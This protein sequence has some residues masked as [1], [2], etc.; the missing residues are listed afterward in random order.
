MLYFIFSFF[1]DEGSTI[2]ESQTFQ[3]FESF[4]NVN[5]GKP[6]AL[7]SS[8]PFLPENISFNDNKDKSVQEIEEGSGA[9]LPFQQL[10][11]QRTEQEND[12]QASEQPFQQ[13][14][15]NEEEFLKEE[16]IFESSGGSDG[17]S[18][19]SDHELEG[20]GV[21]P[22][23]VKDS[24]EDDNDSTT[25]ETLDSINQNIEFETTTL[26]T[27]DVNKE[28]VK[29]IQT[30]SDISF[31]PG[32]VP[33][34]NSP[35]NVQSQLTVE[36]TEATETGEPFHL[37][38]ISESYPIHNIA[39][40]IEAEQ[41]KHL[42]GQS[43]ETEIP[44]NIEMNESTTDETIESK[45]SETFEFLSKISEVVHSSSNVNDHEFVLLQENESNDETTTTTNIRYSIDEE[46][47]HHVEQDV[48]VEIVPLDQTEILDSKNDN[49]SLYRFI[50]PTNDNG[51]DVEEA[52]QDAMDRLKYNWIEEQVL[53]NERG[54][55]KECSVHVEKVSIFS[56]NI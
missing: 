51:G 50:F 33:I 10:Q 47:D 39:F 53:V 14:Q 26:T 20:S 32:N 18:G 52:D 16:I 2:S 40:S 21:V 55:P 19:D 42:V 31:T 45:A 17:T 8:N 49:E 41:E 44:S 5:D 6:N 27:S 15:D 36:S 11:Q 7:S 30:T 25:Q 12:G 23:D 46:D 54:V 37:P 29:D 38:L 22:N 24:E 4:I 43:K 9:G 48:L 34:E 3:D 28:E 13:R 56:C 35:E 1:D